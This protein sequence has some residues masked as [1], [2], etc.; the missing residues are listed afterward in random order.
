MRRIVVAAMAAS[1]L[2][3]VP[4]AP[5][6]GFV[7]TINGQSGGYLEF[8][9]LMKGLVTVTQRD[10]KAVLAFNLFGLQPRTKYRLVASS[11]RCGANGGRVLARSFTT[12]SGGRSWDPVPIRADAS[13]IRSIVVRERD[14]GKT[15][16]CSGRA[17]VPLG[18]GNTV[19][20]RAPKGVVLVSEAG[21]MWQLVE[22]FSGLKPR[23]KYRTV[24]LPGGCAPG[25]RPLVRKDFRSNAGGDAVVRVRRKQ[26]G[27]KSIGAVALVDRSTGEVTFCR[28]VQV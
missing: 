25:S 6:S 28:T 17:T 26:V 11:K 21:G 27:G 18:P 14:S 4:V 1:G 23:T 24:A 3:L 12:D 5:S 22:S 19:K 15:V 16:A 10:A 20:I 2:V 8:R 9:G 13:R 7:A